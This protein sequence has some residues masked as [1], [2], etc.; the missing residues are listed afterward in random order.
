MTCND[1][2]NQLA[3]SDMCCHP[4][5][6]YHGTDFDDRANDEADRHAQMMQEQ[7]TRQGAGKW[8]VSTAHISN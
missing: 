3:D 7:R 1:C 5:T 8:K 4:S 6:K 2:P